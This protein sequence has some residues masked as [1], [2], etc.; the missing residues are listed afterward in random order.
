M[1]NV[2]KLLTKVLEDIPPLKYSSPSTGWEQIYL[3]YTMAKR[4]GKAVTV[5]GVSGGGGITL[6]ANAYKD[7]TTLPAKYR[8][9]EDIP[10]VVDAVGGSERIFGRIKTT[11]IVSIY[12][13][14]ATAYWGFSV[15]FLV[16]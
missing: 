3:N 10:F 4:K 14:G 8:P 16:D 9:T 12:S 1:L 6:T 5:I 15:T 2:K 13:S 7:I 11:G